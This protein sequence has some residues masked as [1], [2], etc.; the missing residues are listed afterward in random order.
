MVVVGGGCRWWFGIT[1]NLAQL[2][3]LGLA[4]AWQE[5]HKIECNLTKF[6]VT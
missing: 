2:V 1:L 4:R 5:L 6:F 3:G